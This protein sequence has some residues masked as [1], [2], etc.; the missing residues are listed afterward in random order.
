MNVSVVARQGNI[1][2]VAYYG[3]DGKKHYTLK[4]YGKRKVQHQLV[5]DENREP[6]PDAGMDDSEAFNKFSL[7]QKRRINRL[8]ASRVNDEEVVDLLKKQ[9]HS[10]DFE[11]FK[12]IVEDSADKGIWGIEIEE[13]LY[14]ETKGKK[15][16]NIRDDING[17]CQLCWYKAIKCRYQNGTLN[18]VKSLEQIF[19]LE[20]RLKIDTLRNNSCLLITE[21][22]TDKSSLIEPIA[23]LKGDLQRQLES[24]L[25]VDKALIALYVNYDV[26]SRV[27]FFSEGIQSVTCLTYVDALVAKANGEQYLSVATPG[28]LCQ[29]LEKIVACSKALNRTFEPFSS[30]HYKWQQL[31]ICIGPL[32]AAIS[33][34]VNG[35]IFKSAVAQI[36]LVALNQR[37]HG[38]ESDI[39]DK[40]IRKKIRQIVKGLDSLYRSSMNRRV[41]LLL[42]GKQYLQAQ[43]DGC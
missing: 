30:G 16:Q 18:A 7:F 41:S 10:K 14:R 3:L 22:P 4:W 13:F 33:D 31:N 24:V 27:D 1:Y 5:S 15:T 19:N 37:M 21:V 17:L 25:P 43:K 11:V 23:K 2:L 35:N 38:L 20:E 12:K 42:A 8:G 39:E 29:L 28:E 26:Y 40:G 34:K 6:L 36:E 9:F 32:V